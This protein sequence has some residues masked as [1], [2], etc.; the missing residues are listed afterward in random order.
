MINKRGHADQ[1]IRLQLLQIPNCSLGPHHLPTAGAQGHD[2][3]GRA[4]I[5][6]QPERQ[7]RREREHVQH[8][9]IMLPAANLRHPPRGGLQIR[10]V[11][12]RKEEG[13]RLRAAASREG[14]KN[15]AK[16]RFK[17]LL[18]PFLAVH[19]RVHHHLGPARQH[20]G[21]GRQDEIP[22]LLRLLRRRHQVRFHSGR[23]TSDP[24]LHPQRFRRQ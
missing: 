11:L 16:L 20:P 21:I 9:E 19:Q 18:H 17:L 14:H 22:K 24:I 1:H 15:R 6:R 2:A 23:N 7:V 10:D 5:M 4:R 13:R 8:L 3:A 12:L